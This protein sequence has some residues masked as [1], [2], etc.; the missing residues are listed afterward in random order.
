V[1]TAVVLIIDGRLRYLADVVSAQDLS[2]TGSRAACLSAV[3]LSSP[4]STS[5]GSS[6]FGR[7]R[8]DLVKAAQ[9]PLGIWLMKGF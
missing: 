1:S 8:G 9:L 4:S 2:G 3:N 5:C 7:S 6:A